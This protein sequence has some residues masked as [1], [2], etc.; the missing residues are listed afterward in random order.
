MR[1]IG[2]VQWRHSAAKPQ[3]KE[4]EPQGTA[5][6]EN[7]KHRKTRHANINPGNEL[8]RKTHTKK[9][10]WPDSSTD[11]SAIPVW[12]DCPP[13]RVN[14]SAG[15]PAG[16]EHA[17]RH[18]LPDAVW[19]HQM[20]RRTIP[21]WPGA[22]QISSPSFPRLPSGHLRPF[23]FWPWGPWARSPPIRGCTFRCC[24]SCACR[25]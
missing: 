3:R 17:K 8:G 10:K 24:R 9:T 25:A 23:S 21:A 1:P 6:Q 11:A 19:R 5:K 7:R 20:D 16:E 15:I 12:A 22:R 14:S 18:P 2:R 4:L 13:P